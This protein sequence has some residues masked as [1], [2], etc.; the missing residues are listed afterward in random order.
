M[1]LKQDASSRSKICML[2]V[3]K[4]TSTLSTLQG[5]ANCV[6]NGT[7]RKI[8]SSN[9]CILQQCRSQ[10]LS[11][12]FENLVHSI[13]R[14]ENSTLEIDVSHFGVLHWQQLQ[15]LASAPGKVAVQVWFCEVAGKKKKKLLPV[16]F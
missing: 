6:I 4:E 15:P 16:I 2:V 12:K 5:I 10:L 3:R 1:A 14:N 9:R 8:V 13:F 7:T 11:V